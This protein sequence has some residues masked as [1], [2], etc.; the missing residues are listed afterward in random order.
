MD[1]VDVWLRLAIHKVWRM[2]DSKELREEYVRRGYEHLSDF[3]SDKIITEV[4]QLWKD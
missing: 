2:M 3:S 1:I 4:R